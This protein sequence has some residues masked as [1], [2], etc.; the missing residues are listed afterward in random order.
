MG[1]SERALQW[2]TWPQYGPKEVAAVT[3]VVISNQLFAANE[4][5]A[6]ESDFA[7][8][9][10]TTHAV[11]M[12]NATQGLHLSLA[13]IG[14]GEGD[15]VIVTPCSWISSASCVLMQNAVPVFADIEAE[16]LGLD[17]SAVER[18]IS[19]RTRAIILVHILGYPARVRE[20]VEIGR[21]YGIPVI[22]DASHAPGAEVNGKRV[23]SFG[24]MGVFSLH[25]RKA[26]STGDGGIICTDDAEVARK[27][28]HLRSFGDAEL[29]YNYRMTEF[30]AALGQLGLENLDGHNAERRWAAEYLRSAFKGHDWI[31]VRLAREGEVGVFYAVALEVTMSDDQA[32]EFV[33]ELEAAGIPIRKVFAPLNRHPHFNLADTPPRGYPWKSIN[34]E[35]A[36]KDGNYSDLDLPVAYEYCYGRVLEL[37][38]H[39]GI[40]AQHL[41]FFVTVATKSYQRIKEEV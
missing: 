38:T 16:S 2:P 23:G 19:N 28:W 17:P 21:K 7:S 32:T 3:R 4:V 39:P 11:A 10:G 18:A 34:Y 8:Y 6:F 40:T 30:S 9:I 35:G 24:L 20:I 15:E 31:A 5:R 27:I 12:G 13:A 22:E 37:Y 26:I 33:S 14:V 1:D 36:M 41:E 25:Q 29:S